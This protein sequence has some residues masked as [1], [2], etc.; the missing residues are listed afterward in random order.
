V[1]RI[2]ATGDLPAAKLGNSD[3][4]EIGD[5]VLAIGNPFELETTVSAGIISAKERELSSI[6]RSKFLQTDAAINPGN[7]GGPLVNLDGEV[8]GINTAIASNSGGYQG[9]GFAIPINQAKWITTQLV[10]TGSV[11]RG[12]LGVGIEEVTPD[13]AKQ[14]GVSRGEGVLVAE[15]F[16]DSPA[17]KAGFEEGDLIVE[18][19]GHAVSK[20]RDLQ[21]VVERTPID[22]RQQVKVIRG[23][24]PRTLE[25]VVKALPGNLAEGTGSTP[26][27]RQESSSGDAYYAQD[28][29]LEV[30]GLTD[31]LAE[32]AGFK[33]YDGV[34]ISRV[35]D[36]GRAAAKGLTSGMLIRKVGRTPVKNL[37]DFKN[38]LK[39]EASKE[40][41][42]L[43]VRT[44]QGNRF[45]VVDLK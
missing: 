45:V 25:I 24:K 26:R 16:P 13:L 36:D 17:T 8:I 4:L 29:G 19:G 42:L 30:V 2:K 22:S 33:G 14:F 21:E 40:S 39:Q 15:V 20:P 5:W 23:G 1:L 37:Q 6:R 41:V 35:D 7:S 18:F 27:Q 32:Q 28:L 10:K 34:L 3:D 43:Q 9:I 12:Y 11:Q 44:D 38:A 31:E